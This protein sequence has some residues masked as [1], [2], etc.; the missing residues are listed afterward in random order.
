MTKIK[1]RIISKA[2]AYLQ[3]MEKTWAKFQKDWY[4]IVWR[5]V[6]MRYPLSI[7]WGWTSHC[8]KS[9]KKWPKNYI[10]ITCTSSYYEE[11]TCKVSEWSVQNCKRSRAK[12]RYMYPLSV[13]WS[14]K[15]TKLTMWKSN[16]KWSNNYIQP[17]THPHTMK[18]THTKFQNHQYKTVGGVMLTR[19][20][21]CLDI[22]G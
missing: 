2:H 6:L 8:R 10:Q 14:R 20:I 11:N 22:E 17:Q 16:K 4:K 15:M 7:Y 9:D 18:N 3:T 21:H 13:Y 19:G 5:V 12:K 1:A